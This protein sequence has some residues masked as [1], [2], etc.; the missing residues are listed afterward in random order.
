[1]AG[2]KLFTD[3]LI[4]G[5]PPKFLATTSILWDHFLARHIHIPILLTMSKRAAEIGHEGAPLKGGDRPEKMDI[6]DKE[7]GDFEDEY[8]DEFESED[9]IVEAGVDGRPD[10]E[11]EA[12]EGMTLFLWYYIQPANPCSR[13]HGGRPGHFYRWPPQA[14]ARPGADARPNNLRDAAQLDDAVAVSILR[15]CQRRAG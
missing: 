9:E 11:R 5:P 3:K 12:E 15:H 6:D 10:A 13:C 2:Q 4:R 8:E 14:R 7:M 1:M